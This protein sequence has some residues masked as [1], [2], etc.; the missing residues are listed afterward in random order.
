[1]A[2]DG[3]IKHIPPPWSLK[4][5]AYFFMFWIPASQA[6]DFPKDIAFSPLERE[7][8]FASAAA[9]SSPKGGLA[10][11]QVYR[12]SSSPVGPY[13][14]F[15]LST[16][17]HSYPVEENGKRKE[18]SNIRTT[19]IYVSQKTTCRNWRK[20]ES[21]CVHQTPALD[22]NISKTGTHPSIL[23]ASN[24]TTWPVVPLKSRSSRMT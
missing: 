19:R 7:S 1:M 17:H 13:D 8:S 20:D 11:I 21:T 6:A 16:G 12:Y 22:T 5:T 18:K 24:S 14:G 2:D 15:I 4:G 9:S 10:T 3:D 23:P